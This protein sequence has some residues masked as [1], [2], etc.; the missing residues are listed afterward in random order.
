MGDC[1]CPLRVVRVTLLSARALRLE[2]GLWGQPAAQASH[3]HTGITQGHES[4]GFPLVAMSIYLSICLPVCLSDL[5]WSSLISSD[6]IWSNLICLP[7]CQLGNQPTNQSINQ[8]I[9]PSF[10]LSVGPSVRPFVCRLSVCVSISL[11]VNLSVS[12]SI[13][14]PTY[15]SYLPTYLSVHRSICQSIYLSS[16]PSIC[17]SLSIYLSSEAF[18]KMWKRSFCARRPSNW[19]LKMWKR[20]CLARLDFHCSDHHCSDLRCSD[21]HCRNFHCSD[22]HCPTSIYLSIYIYSISK[23]FSIQT[24][25]YLCLLACHGL[26]IYFDRHAHRCT[27]TCTHT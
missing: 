6:P 23:S 18:V 7:S 17:L 1:S 11:S 16:H 26:S 9:R 15:L 14:V 12:P 13:Y 8:S 2:G 5:I 20:S 27:C 21:T 3:G 4:H 22:N 10:R 24:S 19:R 25:T